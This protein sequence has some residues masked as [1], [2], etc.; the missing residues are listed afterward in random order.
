MKIT[1]KDGK[2][3]RL[4]NA[5]SR[6][7]EDLYIHLINWKWD[8]ITPEVGCNQHKD[9]QIPYDAIL[10]ESVIANL[11]ILYPEIRDALLKHNNKYPFR[12]H[13]YF[14]H[15]A[16]SQAANINLFLP[17]LLH[18]N[19]D[20]VLSKMKSDFKNLA[21]DKLYKGFRIEF[22]DDPYNNLKDKNDVSG[23]DTDIS[24]A[25]YNNQN[26][27]CLWLIEHKLSER[28]FT[29]CGGY[30]SKGRKSLHDCNKSFTE[31]LADKEVC[32]YNSTR[33]YRYWNITEEN[34]V[35][36]VNHHIY[37][38]CP[39]KGGMNQLWRNQLLGLSIEYDERQPYEKVY[40]SVVHHPGNKSLDNT[41]NKYKELITNNERFSTFTS[42]EVVRIAESL[43][44][45]EL[46]KWAGWYRGL[47]MV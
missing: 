39:F 29:P 11:P 4:P 22:W 7:Q 8:H 38:D 17:T 15:M 30:K 10:P 41:I 18:P 42:D 37:S 27:L 34:K 3:Y 28:E 36:F 26:E 20:Q 21:V 9:K 35:F 24:I 25:Y 40:F 33:N 23:T 16:S 47:Y 12:I 32:Y 14:N 45:A 13:K 44:D 19:A 46:N 31:I 5:L 2:E 6:F 1:E 43:N